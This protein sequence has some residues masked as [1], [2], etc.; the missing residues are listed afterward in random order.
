MSVNSLDY[1]LGIIAGALVIPIFAVLFK[2]FFLQVK[3]ETNILVCRFGKL[4]K[5]I[6]KPGLHF[7][8]DRMMPWMK[9]IAVSLKKDFRCIEE[10]HVNDLSGTTLI[11][12]LWYEFKIH[13]PV[14][15]AFHIESIEKF[16]N[17]IVI[18]T[19]TSILGT[20]EFKYILENRDKVNEILL[21]EIKARLQIWGI[22]LEVLFLSRFSPLSEISKQ[23]FDTISAQLEKTKADIEENGRLAVQLLEAQTTA[24]ISELLAE[25]K[26]QY[27]LS[28]SAAYQEISKNLEVFDAYK[29]LYKL[30]LQKPHRMV[31]FQGFAANELSP[32]DA[33]MSVFPAAEDVSYGAVPK[34]SE[35]PTSSMQHS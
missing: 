34:V 10:I 27:S 29:K 3:N 31:S 17:S 6:T 11:I 32:L 21:H 24:K 14:K 4:V 33:A 7:Q 35:L 30:S 19:T 15:A 18:S 20:F 13:S 8:I 23:L 28:V 25:A 5:V 1:L 9:F 12:D 22:H 16:M 26:G 2:C